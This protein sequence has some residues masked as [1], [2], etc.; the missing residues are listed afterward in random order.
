MF[1]SSLIT[2]EK[3]SYLFNCS[4]GTQRNALDQGIKFTK[5][6]S[7]FYSSSHSNCYLGTFGLVMSRTEQSQ[8]K[9]PLNQVN[10]YGPPNFHS[11]FKHC[12]HICPVPLKNNI[13]NYNQIK[14]GFI[15]EN[16]SNSP[17]YK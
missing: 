1:H 2:F 9:T 13:Y 14:E 16:I 3:D 8:A 15:N 4:D 7:I 11:N 5:I 10:L 12:S 6:N 17:I